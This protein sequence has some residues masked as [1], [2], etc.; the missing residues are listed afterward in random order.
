MIK[1][2]SQTGLFLS[3]G[4]ANEQKTELSK[5]VMLVY[6]GKF[7][8]MDGEVDVGDEDLDKLATNHNDRLNK[9]VAKLGKAFTGDYPKQFSPPVQLDHSTSA[10]HTIGRLS[11]PLTLGEHELE[12]GTK[13][14]A[15]FGT[16]KILGK[17]NIEKVEDGR[18]LN[19][20]GGFDFANHKIS[21]LS[22]TPFPAAE[23]AAM[24]SRFGAYKGSSITVKKDADGMFYAVIDGEAHDDQLH[25]TEKEAVDWA[26]RAIDHFDHTNKNLSS[27]RARLAQE[28]EKLKADRIAARD[29][30]AEIQKAMAACTDPAEIK[31][32]AGQIDTL[33]N[34]IKD[35]EDQIHGLDKSVKLNA[36]PKGEE[37]MGLKE[38]KERLAMLEKCKKHLMEL[39]QLSEE[40]A[41]KKLGEMPEEE[42]SKMAGERDE[43]EKKLAE[44]KTKE[45]EKAKNLMAAPKAELIK[46]SKEIKTANEKVNLA[47]KKAALSARFSRLK[48]EAK[49]TPAELKKIDFDK[50]AAENTATQE[51]VLKT[52]ESRE[53]VIATGMMGTVKAMTGGQL[54]QALKKLRMSQEEL[55]S[56]LN[57]PSKREEAL[58]ELSKLQAEEQEMVKRFGGDVNEVESSNLADYDKMYGD[59]KALM[60]QG[61]HDEAKEHLKK[62]LGGLKGSESG[63][64]LSVDVEKQMSALAEEIKTLQTGY[65]GLLK[66]MAPVVGITENDLK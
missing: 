19:V 2:L 43:H 33:Q 56:R 54:H 59:M 39:S 23:E 12:D 57:M 42:L 5:A 55:T 25:D 21:E 18:W 58:K 52:Y 61:K 60:D 65:D 45:D 13:V 44:D 66:L 38:L 7:Q 47:S 28:V 11:G 17:E 15:L 53:N 51:A 26:K 29:E 34:K 37:T 10:Q 22:V 9:V 62:Y 36:D 6:T 46:F 63:A 14:K 8:S 3:K 64:E 30:C 49:I 48:A 41:E 50:L 4:E 35:L 24:L 40:D 1:R 32:Y 31:K 20:S 16:A 27:R